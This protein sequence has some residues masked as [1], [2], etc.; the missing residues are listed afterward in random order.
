[1]INSGTCT[2]NVRTSSGLRDI[3]L[4]CNSRIGTVI[5]GL[6]SLINSLNNKFVRFVVSAVVTNTFVTG[7]SGY[8]HTFMLITGHLAKRRNRTLADLSGAAM[9]DIIRKIVNI[10]IVRSIVTKMKVTFTNIPTVN[11]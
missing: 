9:E 7:T 1:M 2:F 4:G 11:L 6:T 10:T 3:L 5:D 8:R